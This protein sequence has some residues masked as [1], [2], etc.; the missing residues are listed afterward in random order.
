MNTAVATATEVLEIRLLGGFS[1]T[2]G[3]HRVPDAVWS[4]KR[5][6]ALI[7]LLAVEPSHRLH[8]EQVMEALWP[9]LDPMA[10]DNNLRFTLFAARK[11]LAGAGSRPNQFIT[12][13]GESLSLG[14]A[15]ALTIDIDRF[16]RAATAAWTVDD[17][18][19]TR[20]ALDLY[21]G[22][23]LPEDPYED[24]A[25]SRRAAL[26][27]AHLSLL[28]RLAELQFGEGAAAAAIA[29]L[30]RLVAVEPTDEAA[31]TRLMHVL[32]LTGQRQRALARYEHL[33]AALAREVGAEP[34]A[35]TRRLRDDIRD[36]RYPP[37]P[38]SPAAPV[39]QRGAKTA[40][41]EI[42]ATVGLSLGS[43]GVLPTPTD[44]LIGR[45][46][47]VAEV[48]QLLTGARLVTLTG[49]GGVG[50]TRLA[51]ALAREAAATA[52]AGVIFVDLTPL[53]DPNLVLPAIASAIGVRDEPEERLLRSL[54]MMLGRQRRLL[55]IDNFEQ[56][57]AAASVVAGLLAACPGLR[58]LVTSRVRLRLRGEREYPVGPLRVPDLASRR[59]GDRDLGNVTSSP[60]AMLF[61]E[62][63]HAANSAFALTAENVADVAAI[64]R[65]LDGLPLALELAAAWAKLLPP[66]AMLDRLERG[67]LALTGGSRD[68]PERQQTIR[69]TIAWSHDLLADQ[70]R[71]L[72]RRLA[73]FVGGWTIP[74]AEAVAG[75]GDRELDVL[76]G[77]R[78]LVDQSLVVGLGNRGGET[79]YTM[80]ET[81]R[82]FALDRLQASGEGG[83]LR[84]AHATYLLT[85]AEAAAPWLEREEQVT[86]YERLEIEHA[87]VRAAI[88]WFQACDDT[89]SVLRFGIALWLFWFNFR[90]E[91]GLRWLADALA[92]GPHADPLL[93]AAALHGAGNLARAVDD[94]VRGE[95][96]HREELALRR[97]VGDETGIGKTLLPLGVEAFEQE[98]YARAETLLT[99]SAGRLRASGD[100][101]A[102]AIAV[103]CLGG[104]AFARGDLDGANAQLTEALRIG[105]RVGDRSGIG[106]TLARLGALA[107]AAG[108]VSTATS[109]YE[110]GLSI[111]RELGAPSD[112]A[113]GL[114]ELG[115]LAIEDGDFDRA[116]TLLGE[117]L[118]LEERASSP[119]LRCSLPLAVGRLARVRGDLKR[120]AAHYAA[121][122]D[123]VGQVRSYRHQYVAE[124]LDEIAAFA[125]V[126]GDRV[127]AARLWGAAS[128]ERDRVGLWHQHGPQLERLLRTTRATMGEAAFAAAWEAGRNM[129][130]DAALAI[131]KELT[132]SAGAEVNLPTRTM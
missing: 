26:R 19:L 90:A 96:F 81:I 122:L 35:A 33:V 44:A 32:A 68:A 130:R 51:L 80:L 71:L 27:A 127:P 112:I 42:A 62:R 129:A 65:G 72:F 5:A 102:L 63:A 54:T 126:T 83:T 118:A 20:A 39:I 97:A 52:P 107:M 13:A 37:P 24:W 94:P 111:R 66:A 95:V 132:G 7:K 2:V 78:E 70:E 100:L 123:Q 106:E 9:E 73:V 34:E 85:L 124:A 12:R 23:L 109:C 31:Q 40:S 16:E 50:K 28:R 17:V 22:E 47:E 67:R 41:T 18:M 30:E 75:H 25:A 77:L 125:A 92:D 38:A 131:A 6:A 57:V 117:A 55:V 128:A 11:R 21:A 88:A 49:P 36:G 115:M 60:A 103:E 15:E 120:A 114:R 104:L 87:N 64:C 43:P 69:A 59:R 93:R 108:D 91:E 99:E 79:R 29:A 3:G 4:R 116:E 74:A 10:A 98:D 61:V 105:R 56:V 58:M 119:A 1:V 82:E 8:R 76:L 14:P 45:E 86:W 48:G 101:W 84:A 113:V 121:A 53:R 89:E 46:R 110:E